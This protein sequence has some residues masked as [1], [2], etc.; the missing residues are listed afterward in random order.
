MIG[1]QTLLEFSQTTKVPHFDT[2]FMVLDIDG[3]IEKAYKKQL[4]P[5]LE[6]KEICNSLKVILMGSIDAQKE[7]GLT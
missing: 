3:I 7:G 6:I 4:I 5:A 1:C 2:H